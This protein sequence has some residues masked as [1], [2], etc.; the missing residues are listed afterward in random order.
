[1][2]R[3]RRGAQ[4]EAW[5]RA[6][7][8]GLLGMGR[9]RGLVGVA[10]SGGGA[11]AA[12]RKGLGGATWLGPAP[13]AVSAPP[14][15]QRRL[16]PSAG[17]AVP[18][19]SGHLRAAARARPLGLRIKST[20]GFRS[21]SFLSH[22]RKT[23][24]C[25]QDPTD[26]Q[27]HP[28]RPTSVWPRGRQFLPGPR[29]LKRLLP[30]PVWTDLP[31]VKSWCLPFGEG[32]TLPWGRRDSKGRVIRNSQ[33]L[34]RETPLRPGPWRA[35]WQARTPGLA[36]AEF[37]M[38]ARDQRRGRAN[39]TPFNRLV[40]R[41]CVSSLDSRLTDVRL[42]GLAGSHSP[43]SRCS[44]NPAGVKRRPLPSCGVWTLCF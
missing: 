2:G 23:G 7:G 4:K 6:G 33:V 29:P 43:A 10:S 24:N 8:R 35:V 22:I 28:L 20:L 3:R 11:A 5:P 26:G 1:M 38:P 12:G 19:R 9:G 30:P 44:L 13:R 31:K 25:R 36:L 34:T 40:S 41:F 39:S 37:W 27:T 14:E 18:A 15:L 21:P 42:A 16:V 17:R 32:D